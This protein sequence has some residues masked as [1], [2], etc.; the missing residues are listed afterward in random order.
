[1][2]SEEEDCGPAVADPPQRHYHQLLCVH[3]FTECSRLTPF[4]SLLTA[5]FS[6][7]LSVHGFVFIVLNMI[8]GKKSQ[9]ARF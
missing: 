3:I 9:R 1:M 7:F 4:F 8:K 2:S 5:V 6:F